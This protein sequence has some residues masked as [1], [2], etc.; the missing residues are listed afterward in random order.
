MHSIRR[1]NRGK[2]CLTPSFHS[3]NVPASPHDSLPPS[4]LPPKKRHGITVP[5]RVIPYDNGTRARGSARNNALGAG[6]RWGRGG[7]ARACSSPA[8]AGPPDS[9]AAVQLISLA[10]LPGGSNEPPWANASRTHFLT[11]CGCRL[12]GNRMA[13]S[14]DE[15]H[16]P[17]P[18][19]RKLLRA[20]NFNARRYNEQTPSPSHARKSTAVQ[21][22]SV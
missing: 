7:R 13:E 1:E 15:R 17:V 12:T 18:K 3:N 11:L 9:A 22:L 19:D 5:R 4:P 8:R 14:S 16:E 20:E 10:N 21:Y 2:H 6:G